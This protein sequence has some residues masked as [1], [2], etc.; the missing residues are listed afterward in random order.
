MALSSKQTCYTYCRLDEK[1][2]D[3]HSNEKCC[4][5]ICYHLMW[6]R[7]L[8]LRWAIETFHING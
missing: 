6:P 2:V 7:A 5:Q 8:A 4:I 1:F 3:T